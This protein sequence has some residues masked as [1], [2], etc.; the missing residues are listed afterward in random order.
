VEV[1]A[2]KSE[3]RARGEATPGSVVPAEH[4]IGGECIF[5]EALHW[6]EF[7][8]HKLSQRIAQTQ[9]MSYKMNWQFSTHD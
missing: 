3:T 9:V 1:A 7:F 8:P 4:H 2:R 5:G 6:S